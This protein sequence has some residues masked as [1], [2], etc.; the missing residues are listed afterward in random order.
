[1]YDNFIHNMEKQV[2]YTNLL[3]KKALMLLLMIIG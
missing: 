1:M 2:A 3:G